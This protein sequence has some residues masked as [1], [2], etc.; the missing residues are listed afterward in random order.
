MGVGA[1]IAI[2]NQAEKGNWA[3]FDSAA[4]INKSIVSVWNCIFILK[5]QFEEIVIIL[6]D[7]RI[8]ISPTRFLNKVIVPEAADGEFW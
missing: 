7:K 6:I 4:I 5:F 1:A 2:G 3:L 8:I